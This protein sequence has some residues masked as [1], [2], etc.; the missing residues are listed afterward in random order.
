MPKSANADPILHKLLRDK[1][2]PKW[3]TSNTDI[4]DPNLEK[5]RKDTAEPK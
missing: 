3:D 2:A 1:E 4:C 5:L